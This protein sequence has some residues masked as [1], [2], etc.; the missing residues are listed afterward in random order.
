MARG[1]QGFRYRVR[2]SGWTIAK[3]RLTGPWPVRPCRRPR[4]T[5][6]LGGMGRVW[7]SGECRVWIE[8][9]APAFGRLCPSWKGRKADARRA[10]ESI[11]F[12]PLGD[13]ASAS[14]LRTLPEI[15]RMRTFPGRPVRFAC[16]NS[17][18]SPGF[19]IPDRAGVDSSEPSECKCRHP[20]RQR[21]WQ[22]FSRPAAGCPPG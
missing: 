19:S 8:D 5:K 2:F 20:S 1:D 14:R 16:A 6:A 18:Q 7:R 13:I 11:A 3:R 15:R 10:G 22:V 21:D 12:A 17:G 9:A 4:Q